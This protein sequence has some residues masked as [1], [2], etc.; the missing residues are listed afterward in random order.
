MKKIHGFG[1]AILISSLFAASAFSREKV[2]YGTDS[3]VEAKDFPDSY[4]FEMARSTAAQMDIRFF[5]E[6][7]SDKVVLRDLKY[8]QFANLCPEERFAD[9][10][11]HAEC[12]AFLV[13]EDL[14]ATAGHCVNELACAS[15]LLRWVFDYRIENLDGLELSLDNI[16]ECK[17]VLLHKNDFVEDYALIRLDRPVLDRSPLSFRT[18]GEVEMETPLVIIGH[19]GGIPTKIASDAQVRNTSSPYTFIANLDAFGGNSGSPVLN[20]ETGIVEGILVRGERDYELD[21]ERGCRRSRICTDSQFFG[22]RGESS[23]RITRLDIKQF[24]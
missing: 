15:G 7:K 17:E 24:L 10:P 14:L 1:L 5:R 3:R 21:L 16:Y 12:S 8:Q 19:P 20:A 4:F 6:L 18:Q 22:C 9:Q 11:A 23:S 13:G 2:I